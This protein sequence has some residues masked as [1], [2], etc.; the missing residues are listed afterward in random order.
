MTSVV[1]NGAN[2]SPARQ[3]S[4]APSVAATAILYGDERK[5]LVRVAVYAAMLSVYLALTI[6]LPTSLALPLAH[7][8]GLVPTAN[9]LFVA[10]MWIMGT[11]LW[12]LAADCRSASLYGFGWLMSAFASFALGWACMQTW[13]PVLKDISVRDWDRGVIADGYYFTDG[14]V[15]VEFQLFGRLRECASGTQRCS[16]YEW[17]LAPVFASPHCALLNRTREVLQETRNAT[18]GELLYAVNATVPELNMSATTACDVQFIAMQVV[19]SHGVGFIGSIGIGEKAQKVVGSLLEPPDPEDMCGDE[20]SGGLCTRL[21]PYSPHACEPTLSSAFP[22][23]PDPTLLGCAPVAT[24]QA[25][26]AQP[27]LPPSSNVCAKRY[28]QLGN[29]QAAADEGQ[30]AAAVMF[31]LAGAAF[32]ASVLHKCKHDVG[33]SNGVRTLKSMARQDQ[34]RGRDAVDLGV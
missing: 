8:F 18:T 23:M 27:F 16:E 19:P 9:L 25:L 14:Y 10:P 31:I 28:F 5:Q 13:A 17:S 12:R 15:G 30:M 4:P 22:R 29:L 33:F 32:V 26:M 3:R 1:L 24:C 6:A 7:H 21:S 11:C 2:R 20:G 34:W